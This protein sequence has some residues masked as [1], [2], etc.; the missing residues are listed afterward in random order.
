MNLIFGDVVHFAKHAIYSIEKNGERKIEKNCVL[1]VW[2][3]GVRKIADFVKNVDNR[4]LVK[5]LKEN[6]V[7]QNA[8][9]LISLLKKEMV[10]GNG[11]D[12]YIQMDMDILLI[13]KKI[14]KCMFIESVIDCSREIFLK[15]CT[16]AIIVI[17]QDVAILIIYGLGRLK[18]ICRMQKE[19]ED[20]GIKKVTK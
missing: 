20:Y 5:V 11:K 4:L 13:M 10:V 8:K 15:V 16:C 6:I 19:K 12:N 2:S 14:K 18:K 9:S 1:D 17:I 7:V 3:Y